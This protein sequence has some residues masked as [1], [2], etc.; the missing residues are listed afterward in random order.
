VV[1]EWWDDANGEDD[2]K[3]EDDANGDDAN[4]EDDTTGRN[5]YCI[6]T[7]SYLH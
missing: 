2:A 4:G 7:Y 3:G 5:I 6:C 1:I